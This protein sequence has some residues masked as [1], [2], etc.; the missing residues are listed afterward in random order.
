M[1]EN[2]D[3]ERG[4]R[5]RKTEKS[6]CGTLGHLPHGMM[7]KKK[8]R[9]RLGGKAKKVK[10]AAKPRGKSGIKSP[11]C[12]GTSTLSRNVHSCDSSGLGATTGVAFPMIHLYFILTQSL[13]VRQGGG[14]GGNA[15]WGGSIKRVDRRG[16]GVGG[17]GF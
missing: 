5:C 8:L 16:G 1:R 17:G 14:L 6:G 10:T 2:S 13:E 15:G 9:P 7:E 11:G 4:R 12:G 3:Q